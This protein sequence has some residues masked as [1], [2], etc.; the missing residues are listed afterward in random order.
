MNPYGVEWRWWNFLFLKSFKNSVEFITYV[1]PCYSGANNNLHVNVLVLSLSVSVCAAN[2]KKIT[3]TGQ[4]FADDIRNFNGTRWLP[5]GVLQ[6]VVTEYH[7]NEVVV[8]LPKFLKKWV[9][10]ILQNI[11]E[12]KNKQ[13][14]KHHSMPKLSLWMHCL[15]PTTIKRLLNVFFCKKS[16]YLVEIQK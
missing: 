1:Y 6:Y 4:L 12:T 11:P 5:V 9:K 10:T 16:V 7:T 14:W 8:M 3:N 15:Q 2:G 13:T